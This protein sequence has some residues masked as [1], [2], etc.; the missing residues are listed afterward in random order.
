M[1][2]NCNGL[3][4]QRIVGAGPE[5][6][7]RFGLVLIKLNGMYSLSRECCTGVCWNAHIEFTAR[8]PQNQPVTMTVKYPIIPCTG[9]TCNVATAYDVATCNTV[10]PTNA[11]HQ[12]GSSYNYYGT[13]GQF[14]QA[15]NH[16]GNIGVFFGRQADPENLI[17]PLQSRIFVRAATLLPSMW[18]CT[19]NCSDGVRWGD[20]AWD[21]PLNLPVLVRQKPTDCMFSALDTDADGILL[22]VDPLTGIY[23]PLVKEEHTWG[24][25]YF[26]VMPGCSCTMT[27]RWT[28]KDP[29]TQ[30][31]TQHVEHRQPLE[32]FTDGR[33]ALE[34]APTVDGEAWLRLNNPTTIVGGC[35]FKLD[36]E[37]IAY[38]GSTT[39][40]NT[41]SPPTP[42]PAVPASKLLLYAGDMTM[43]CSNNHCTPTQM[44]SARITGW[45]QCHS[46]HQCLVAPQPQTVL[47]QNYIRVPWLPTILAEPIGRSLPG[48]S[49][50][51][52]S[53]ATGGQT[54]LHLNQETGECSKYGG[55]ADCDTCED[56]LG[57]PIDLD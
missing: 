57:A 41:W 3:A 29:I 45:S 6:E 24:S 36:A 25:F 22:N 37:M 56:Q 47:T 5:G 20:C 55:K 48:Y 54:C 7:D 35:V 19:W 14:G 15:T 18:C 31:E 39:W 12:W 49:P 38:L 44:E 26:Y 51:S 11:V 50:F 28:D 10:G 32:T 21:L 43:F 8:N 27:L 52:M 53:L 34:Y 2:S 13:Y 9:G 46:Q 4:V 33:F 17:D 1:P 40:A 30:I 42:L 16:N 23:D